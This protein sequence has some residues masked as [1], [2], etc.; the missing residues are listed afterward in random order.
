MQHS[1]YDDGS[2]RSMP[3]QMLEIAERTVND[4]DMAPVI[5]RLGAMGANMDAFTA[6][7]ATI[8]IILTDIE[9]STCMCEVCD[10]LRQLELRVRGV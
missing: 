9:N 7:T 8:G 3:E 6:M 5:N 10:T 1:P 4:P 2:G